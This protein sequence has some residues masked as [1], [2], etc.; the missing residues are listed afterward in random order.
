MLHY[1]PVEPEDPAAAVTVHALSAQE[2]DSIRGQIVAVYRDAFGVPPYA[3]GE[4]ELEE[5]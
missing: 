2:T 4:D 5:S 3:K 1:G